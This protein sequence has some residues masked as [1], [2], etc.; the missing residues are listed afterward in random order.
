VFN[1]SLLLTVKP[2]IDPKIGKIELINEL[3]LLL[4][5]YLQQCLLAGAEAARADEL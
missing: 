1:L 5:I 3:S 2:Y 4:N